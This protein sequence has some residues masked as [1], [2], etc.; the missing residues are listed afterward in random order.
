MSYTVTITEVNPGVDVSANTSQVTV[1]ANTQPIT[2]SYNAVELNGVGV[3]SAT[4]NNSGNLLITLSNST[5]ID[6]G[7]VTSSNTYGNATVAAYLP[8]YTGS[9]AT[10]TDIITLKANIVSLLSSVAGANT[11]IITANTAMKGYVD[12][13]IANTGSAAAIIAANTA[14][15]GYVDA[16]IST[17][18]GQI[19]TANVA[20]KGYV[21]AVTTAWTAANT[22]Q[23]AQIT[24]LQSSVAGA[25]AA[26]T[27]ANVALKGYVDQQFTNLTNGAP[28]ILDTLGEIAT[29]L[30]NNAS[31]STTLLNSIAGA[32]AAIVT[33]NTAMKGYVD[34]VTTAWTTANTTQ[35]TQITAL[36]NSVAGANAAIITANVALKG[37]VDA[38]DSAITTA[39][40][41]ANTTQTGQITAVQNSVAGANAA[42]ITA[43]TAMKGYVD[44][45]TYTNTNVN[46]LLAG[47]ITVGNITQVGRVVVGTGVF[48]SNGTAYSTGS[49]G[50]TYGNTDVAAYLPTYTG[51]LAASSDIIALYANA[52]TQGSQLAGAN[53]AI[54]TANTAMKGYVDAQTAS[55]STAWTANAASQQAQID[56]KAN[57]SS[58]A[59]VATSGSYTDL[60]NTPATYGNTQVGQYLAGTVT[61]GNIAS[62]NGYFWANGTAYSTGG[63]GGTTF[64][65]DLAGNTLTA[66]GT[67][68]ILANA[69]PQSNVAQISTYT[70]GI[71]VTTTPT[72]T[73]GNL[74][75]ANQAVSFI[76]SGNVNLLTSYAAGT[77]TTTSLF[78]YL[79]VTATSANTTMN[80]GDR[81]RGMTGGMDLNLNG[82]NWGALSSA[83]NTLTPILVNGQ[84]LNVYGTGQMGQVGGIG[85]AVTLTPVGGSISA[86]YATGIFPAITYAST[87]A[88]Y[89]ASNVQYARLYTG[90]IAGAANLTIANAIAL[91][92]YTNWATGNVTLVPNA[93]TVLNEDSRSI[94]QTNGNIIATGSGSRY[95]TMQTFNEKVV[96]LGSVGGTQAI[97]MSL[98]TIW[99]M[100]LNSALTINTADITNAVAEQSLTLVITQDGTGSRTL[101]TNIKFV[102]GSKTLSTAAGSI[103]VVTAFYDGTQWLASLARGFA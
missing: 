66:S 72:Y 36:Q 103:D 88:G 49:G 24:A 70:Q 37:Y 98:G 71:V 48:W 86:Q 68:R 26:I 74:N 32:N 62:T 43:N 13:Q 9:L 54:V 69:Y 40:T 29:S 90:A 82:K 10:A 63:A 30:G 17:T 58:L 14:M 92:T 52:A 46:N 7:Q 77:R 1:T 38:Q 11:A 6:A 85:T 12:A 25:N 81:I 102:G 45:Q 41:A 21:D 57:T 22:T 96:A 8:T 3:A 59:T 50:G 89:T 91:H 15:K 78:G 19:T 97:D 61:V 67:G 28:A 44:A 5:V 87:G 27:T 100:T 79:G 39:W 51:G 2:V 16:Q 55:V 60:T 34:A 20:M 33:A 93:Y 95:G 47:N 99:T 101:T 73:S 4:I 65:G 53:A 23:S 42:I 76:G 75:S 64:T 56:A 18:Q 80:T 31:L 84:T 83:S 35:S 94:I